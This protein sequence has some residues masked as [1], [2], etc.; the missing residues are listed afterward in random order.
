MEKLVCWA[1]TTLISAFVGSYLAGYLK[2]KGENLATKEDI[3]DLVDQT[4]QLTQT[5]K[6][7]EAKIDDQVW[8]RQRQWEMKRDLL[9][10]FARTI[11][12]F[13][14]AVMNIGAK[15]ENRGTSIYEA[16]LFSKA[17]AEWKET[18]AK[19]E[20]DGFVAALV[21]SMDTRVALMDLGG[22]LRTA[23][24]DILAKQ[25]QETYKEHH[26][27]IVL[28]LEKIKIIIRNELGVPALTPISTEAA[29]PS[30]VDKP[31]T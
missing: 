27:N 4:R 28:K 24:T 15:I 30:L 29:V 21:I 6:E 2:K 11:S 17:L 12:D 25:T 3:G 16:E 9:L 13:E 1:L 5:T 22:A 26:K 31:R 10:G 19:F 8:N 18:S 23:T 7:I 14:Q 20:Q